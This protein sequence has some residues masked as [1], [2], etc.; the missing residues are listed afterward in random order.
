MSRPESGRLAV[1]VDRGTTWCGVVGLVLGVG[2]GPEGPTLEPGTFGL[3]ARAEDGSI[4]SHGPTP[5]GS[6]SVSPGGCGGSDVRV[7]LWTAGLVTPGGVE[8]RAEVTPASAEGEYWLTV[9]VV[10]GPG[11]GQAAIWWSPAAGLARLPLGGRPGELE[12]RFDVTDE[13]VGNG[14]DEA[15][16]A[17]AKETEAWTEGAFLLEDGEGRNVGAIQLTGA[18]SPPFVGVWD[19]LWLSDGMG[20]ALRA[21]DGGDLILQ[22]VVQPRIQAEEAMLRFNVATRRVVVPAAPNPSELDRWLVARPGSLS[23]AEMDAAIEGAIERADLAEG[24]WIDE[25]GPKLAAAVSK[26]G[27]CVA[28]EEADA[29]WPLLLTGYTVAVHQAESGACQVLFEPNPLQHRRRFRG[30]V[31]EDGRVP[32][33]LWPKQ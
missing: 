20:K 25:F 24:A 12:V 32:A 22:F 30:W 18:E 1:A 19:A 31:G 26:D 11:E 3:R 4:F 8:V 23:D 29:S 16:A 14:A 17:L 9:P 15:L 13:A 28:P 10:T 27:V 33:E 6:I 2:C 5:G 7:A 21:D